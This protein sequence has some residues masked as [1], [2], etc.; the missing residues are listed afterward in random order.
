MKKSKSKESSEAMA[1][2]SESA[3]RPN[4]EA[5][6]VVRDVVFVR[7]LMNGKVDALDADR[8]PIRELCGH[9]MSVWNSIRHRLADGASLVLMSHG[10]ER[11]VD[12]DAVPMIQ[13]WT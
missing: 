2:S 8:R 5:D 6:N 12:L 4:A 7:F 13:R 10:Q 1:E 9:S 11:P 3:D